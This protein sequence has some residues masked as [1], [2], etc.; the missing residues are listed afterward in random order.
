MSVRNG[1]ASSTSTV[2]VKLRCLG[3]KVGRHLLLRANLN[4]SSPEMPND[5]MTM[6]FKL[7]GKCEH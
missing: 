5:R 1:S 2:L 3:D 7:F 4:A 6:A